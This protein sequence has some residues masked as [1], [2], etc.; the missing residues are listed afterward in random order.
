MK[1]ELTTITEEIMNYL[2]EQEGGSSFPELY[3]YFT[4]EKQKSWKRQTLYTHLTILME[5][6]FLRTEGARRKS[7]YIPA[8]SQKTYREHYAEH[9]L[10]ETYDG[11]L[12][13]FVAAFTEQHKISREEA[14]ELIALIQ[15][16][17]EN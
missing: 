9:V 17:K 11:S 2:W 5:K 7:I 8:I 15:D 12:S 4:T 14:D 16:R 1:N 13:K 10:N 3:R 6:G